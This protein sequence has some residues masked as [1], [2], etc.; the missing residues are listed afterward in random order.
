MRR[1]IASCLV[2]AFGVALALNLAYF[3]TDGGVYIYED[4]RVILIIESAMAVGIIGFGIMRLV[5]TFR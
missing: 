1:I 2:I 4:N 3:W 5:N